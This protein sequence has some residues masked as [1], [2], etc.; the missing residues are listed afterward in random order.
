MLLIKTSC[1]L[2]LVMSMTSHAHMEWGP[3]TGWKNAAFVPFKN[4]H[5]PGCSIALTAVSRLMV[6][7]AAGGSPVKRDA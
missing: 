7:G 6:S 1:P 3:G 2:N 4:C 5:A